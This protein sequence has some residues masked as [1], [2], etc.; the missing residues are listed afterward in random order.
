VLRDERSE[1]VTAV[2]AATGVVTTARVRAAELARPRPRD[3]LEA[4][5]VT[6]E[7][8]PHPERDASGVWTLGLVEL[9]PAA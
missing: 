9:G 5:G 7:V 3:R 6:Y 2:A 4:G 8:Q 1:I